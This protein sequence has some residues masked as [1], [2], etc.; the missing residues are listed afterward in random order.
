LNGGDRIFIAPEIGVTIAMDQYL[1]ATKGAMCLKQ[2]DEESK[3]GEKNF[4]NVIVDRDVEWK[5]KELQ[6]AR[7][8][9][10]TKTHIFFANMGG[11]AAKIWVLS[12]HEEGSTA[13][14]KSQEIEISQDSTQSSTWNARSLS[15]REYCYHIHNYE[16]LG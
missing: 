7:G 11:F 16:E 15:R 5:V 9:K 4:R 14:C 10:A 1:C 6:G 8:D 13:P 2:K 12:T 3:E